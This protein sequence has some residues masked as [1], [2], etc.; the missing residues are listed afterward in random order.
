MFLLMRRDAEGQLQVHGTSRAA[1]K[2]EA[3][4]QILD[5]VLG[6]PA[7]IIEIVEGTTTYTKSR[8]Q[9][10]ATFP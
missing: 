4:A 8:V 2:E 10:T 9:V 6:D 5:S 3:I 7:W 1:T